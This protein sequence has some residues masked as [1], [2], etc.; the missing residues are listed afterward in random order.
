MRGRC[1]LCGGEA[2]IAVEA[3]LDCIRSN[4]KALKIVEAKHA[5]SRQKFNLPPKPP[6]DKN[7]IRCGVCVNDCRIGKNK[8]GYCGVVSNLDGRLVR[9]EGL[10][11]SYHDPLPTNCV[12]SRWCPERNSRGYNLAVFYEACSFDCLYC[13]N[14]HFKEQ[15][16]KSNVVSPQKLAVQANERVRC[17]CYFGG[18]PTPQIFHALETGR[19][20]RERRKDVRICFETNGSFNQKIADKVARMVV[21]SGGILKFD[22]KAWDERI[23]LALSGSS[24]KYT[25]ANFARLA[26]DPKIRP[27][28]VASTLLVPNYIDREEIRKLSRFI[29]DCDPSIPWSLLAF[30]PHFELWDVGCTT[31]ELALD[32][33]GIAREH[34][35][36]RTNLGNQWLLR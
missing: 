27:C 32:A 22:L 20:I 34:G 33:I 3:C 12:A 18:D 14:W 35:L 2:S 7:G 26:K 15:L 1:R 17:V 16:S 25:L 8:V 24:N 10:L 13:Q 4:K 5:S 28:L 30:H 29:A 11:E 31:K 9:K 19:L 36:K 6:K 23:N 21:D